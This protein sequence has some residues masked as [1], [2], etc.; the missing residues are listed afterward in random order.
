MVHQVDQVVAMGENRELQRKFELRRV[1]REK[2]MVP[3]IDACGPL[4]APVTEK[5][6]D[7]IPVRVDMPAD[8]LPVSPVRINKGVN[9]KW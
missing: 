2:H 1:R 6:S 3:V 5:P 9:E 4:V 8:E 7:G